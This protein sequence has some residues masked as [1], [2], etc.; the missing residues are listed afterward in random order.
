MRM[1]IRKDMRCR[2]D[3][4]HGRGESATPY[5]PRTQRVC[6]PVR[7]RPCRG[8][9]Q[10]IWRRRVRNVAHWGLKPCSGMLY[11][12][13]IVSDGKGET[14]HHCSAWS[15]GG[16]QCAESSA[17]PCFP[18]RSTDGKVGK[19]VISMP[20]K[21]WSCPG[22]SHVSGRISCTYLFV[23]RVLRPHPS[24]KPIAPWITQA[25]WKPMYTLMA[26]S[27]PCS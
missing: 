17:E 16:D 23:R 20:S 4:H 15:G 24:L 7:N 3:H 5:P 14:W 22:Q 10:S 11:L 6:S 12:A 27:G 26:W 18:G 25:S 1:K 19:T 9:Q 13:S 2:R 8:L 21:S